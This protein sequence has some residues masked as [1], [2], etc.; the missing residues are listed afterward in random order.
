MIRLICLLLMMITFS[1]CAAT[2]TMSSVTGPEEYIPAQGPYYRQILAWQWRTDDAEYRKLG[3]KYLGALRGKVGQGVWTREAVL[4]VLAESR[5]MTTYEMETEDRWATPLEFAERDFRGD[6]EDIAIFM[7]AA[8]K[9]LGYPHEVRVLAVQTLFSGHAL[10]KVEMPDKTW[11]VF[12]TVQPLDD[13][14]ANT[15]LIYTPIVEFDEKI[16]RYARNT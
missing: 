8:L 16:I 3:S 11:Q 2:G 14:A 5:R 4:A 7:M 15:R 12:E 6:C 9:G 13:T 1:G 10:V